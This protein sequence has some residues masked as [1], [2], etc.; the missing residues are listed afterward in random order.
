[1]QRDLQLASDSL[2][3][4]QRDLEA[5]GIADRV[6]THVWSEFGRRAPENASGGTDHGSAGIGF[7]IGSQ[8]NGQQLG[9]H[10][11]RHRRA[12]CVGQPEADDGL[13]RGLR[14]A[15]RAVVQRRLERDH[16]R[17]LR[18]RSG[19]RCSSEVASRC[20]RARRRSRRCASVVPASAPLATGRARPRAGERARSSPTRSRAARSSP[21]RRSS[22]SY[23][24]GEDPHDLRMERL[25]GGTALEDAARLPGRVLRPERDARPGPLPPLV[26]DR[27]PPPARH[28]S[29][30]D[31]GASERAVTRCRAAQAPD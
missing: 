2:L 21:A 30:A 9:A 4:F 20:A 27:E 31:G 10:P 18:L 11:G 25:G 7:L 26:L 14:G 13:P 16:A 8:V 12:R 3:A 29:R 22:S 17:R 19:R 23:N 24:F 6:I 5:R 1:M 28:D 15:P